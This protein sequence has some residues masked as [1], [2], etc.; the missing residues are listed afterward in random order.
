MKKTIKSLALILMLVVALS[1]AVM[2]ASAAD[3]S[4]LS[5]ADC[6]GGVMI[7]SCNK[8]ASGEL[9]IP[10]EYSG[11]KVVKIADRAFE[12]CLGIT[13]VVMPDS[14]KVIGD[15]AFEGCTELAEVSFPYD[16]EKIGSDAFFACDSLQSAMLYP[17]LTEIGAYA[18]FD[19]ES[20]EKVVIPDKIT[21]ISEGAFGECSKLAT[22]S[23]PIS[24]DVIDNDA[25]VG[26]SSIKDV[27]YVGSPIAWY[28]IDW[29]SGNDR[30]FE[31]SY[32]KFNHIHD[33]KAQ[34]TK[35]PD[36]T[37]VGSSV[38]TCACGYTYRDNKVPALGHVVVKVEGTKATCE[39]TGLTAGEKCSRCGTVITAQQIIPATNHNPVND[40][41][42]APTCTATGLTAGSHCETCGHVFVK[43]E[44]VAKV[45]HDFDYKNLNPATLTANGKRVGTC[46]SC[47]YESNETLYSV[48][49]FK[50]STTTYKNYNGKVRTPAVTVQDSEGNTLIKGRDYTVKYDT[51]RKLPGIYN[52]T[53]T[54]QGEYEGTK[55]LSF[56]ILPAKAE[57]IKAKASKVNAVKLTWNE[58]PGATG[59]RIYIFKSANSTEKIKLSPATTNS[60]TLTKDF[61][62]KALVMGATYKISVTPYTKASNGT[63]LFCGTATEFTFKF[64]P[65][66]PTLKASAATKGKATL[67]WTNV[68]GETGYQ[69]Y[70]STDG[71]T[72]KKYSNY[73]GWPDAQTISGLKSGTKYSFKVRAYTAIK[74]NNKTTYVYSAFSAVKSVTV[75]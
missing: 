42:V 52:V 69:V 66:A 58:V 5:F 47:G 11:K 10:G 36:C 7:T 3:V 75:K 68:A 34:V 71:K 50:L 37:N 1:L 2:Q 27:Y 4:A 41:E 49:V 35:D 15:S 13:K 6:E 64:A 60:Y 26:C 73:K 46:K 31:V 29:T 72:Y 25:F 40:K 44:T 8:T 22:L 61:A 62:G 16:L 70:Y 20:L 53:V 9:T 21:V 12:N 45:G 63:Y 39:E 14:I 59:Y 56:K 43:Q 55:T 38:N 23:L 54:L 30:L 19:C 74:A 18:F 33:Y 24:V 32:D 65:A 57:S 67:E 17:N 28:S 48:T 51:G